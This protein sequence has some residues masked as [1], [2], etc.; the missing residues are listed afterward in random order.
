[1]YTHGLNAHQQGWLYC[2]VHVMT[3]RAEGVVLWRF[4]NSGHLEAVVLALSRFPGKGDPRE[5]PQVKG[6]QSTPG[7]DMTAEH[8]YLSPFHPSLWSCPLG[9]SL[10]T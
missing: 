5:D 1:M 9:R 3:E 7:W 6:L 2:E 8:Q 4:L 10:K